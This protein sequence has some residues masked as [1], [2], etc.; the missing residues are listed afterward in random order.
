MWLRGEVGATYCAHY[1]LRPP[2]CR[3][4]PIDERDLADRDLV[5]PDVPCGYWF[6]G[7][8]EGAR[9]RRRRYGV[10]SA[11]RVQERTG[12]SCAV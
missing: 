1:H 11:G 5:M 2:N 7:D 6:E 3:I 4:F 10:R 8:G 12:A 9:Y